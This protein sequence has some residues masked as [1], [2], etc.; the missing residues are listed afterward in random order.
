[1][2]RI[3]APDG[4]LARALPQSGRDWEDRA[5]QR[6]MAQA[7]ARAI[8]EKHHLLVEAGTGTGKSYA[9]LV[10]LILWAVAN[11]KK[12][13]VATHTKALQ[14]QLVERDMPFLRDLFLRR[15]GTEF[16]FALCLGAQNYICPRRLAKAEIGGLFA[17]R[18]E[19][20][21]LKEI[22]AFARKSKTGRNIDLPFEPSTPLWAQ[23]NRE[24]DLCMGRA[25]PLY[26]KSFFYIA[27]REQ[28]KAHVLIANHHLLFAHLA[29]GGNDAGAVL[30][31]FD[32]LVI[33]EAHQA[34]EVASA[35]L[36]IEVVNLGTAR[37][38]E[39]LHNRR[40]GRTV[41]SGSPLPKSDELDKKLVEAADEARE[42]TGRFFENLQLALN[43]DPSR[44]Q[45]IRLRRPHVVENSLDEPL[46]RLE[47]VLKEARK[48]AEAISD[49][50]LIREFEG[51]ATRCFEMR[52]TVQ[53]LLNQSRP[54]YVYWAAIQPRPNDNGRSGRVPRIA[55]CGAPIDVAQ[56]M[57]DT[58]FG[59]INPVILTSATLTT[60]G[61]FEFLRERLGLTPERCA[62][63]VETL[64]LGS[65][66]DYKQNAL[67]YV[68]RDLPDPS[69][70]QAFEAAAIQRAAEVVKSTQGRAFVL[71][72]SFRMVDATANVLRQALPKRIRVLKQG[73]TARGKLLDEFR[74]DIDSVLVGTTSFWQGVDVPGEALTCVVMM[75]LPFAVPD[76]PLVQA[77]VEALREQGRDPFNEY[78]V[79][80]AVMMFRQGF[81]RLI[82]TRSDWGIVAVLDPRV[83]S[84]KYGQVFLRSLPDCA[85]TT[86]L[87]AIAQFA[88]DFERHTETNDQTNA[89]D[90]A[91]VNSGTPIE[92]L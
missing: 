62:T 2:R 57:Q 71:C 72:T 90:A 78:Q 38:I 58:L 21:E 35:Y 23:V 60:G 85:V 15:M 46:G 20:D 70:A 55:L 14:Q 12:I 87:E 43:V 24:S 77:R 36:G 81:G 76:D 86:E 79:P 74:R 25:C 67:L 48:R 39:V 41:L 45:T 29:A 49:E 73:E 92:R 91:P 1:L 40:S 42:A 50:A 27:R 82:R 6:E 69:Q 30:P 66:F 8:D 44:T 4:L 16:R 9:Y 28:E 22:N 63:P 75:K 51:F 59:K 64:T 31:S 17:S 34:E 18:N 61:S 54:G 5:E 33:D 11:N 53:E 84:K 80:Q 19:V 68:A 26:D 56:G 3:F 32:A 88:H 37:L 7:V 47:G 65:P 52:Q 13:L 83:V 89:A 10:P